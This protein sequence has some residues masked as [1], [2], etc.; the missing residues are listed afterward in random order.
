MKTKI[1]VIGS[2]GR[3]HALVWKVNQPN[4]QIYCAPGNG[5]ISTVA[6]CLPIKADNISGLLAFAQKENIDLTI[7]G[8]E[9]P[10]GLGIVDEFQKNHL[11]IFG[12]NKKAAQLETSKEFT[13]NFCRKY[14]LPTPNFATFSETI[15]AKK[16]VENKDFPLVIKASGLAA[17]KGV[18][19]VKNKQEAFLTVDKILEKKEFGKAGEIIVIEEFIVGQEVSMLAVC[20]GNTIIPLVPARDHKPLLDGNK[21][22]NTGGMGSYAPIPEVSKDWLIKIQTELFDPLLKALKKES[23]EYKGIIYAGLILSGDNFY[24]LEFNCRWGDPEAEVIIPLLKTD[25]VTLCYDTIEGKLKKL[26]WKDEYTVT[27]IA[28]SGGYPEKYETGKSITGNLDNQD[29]LI[30]FHC[31]TKKENNNYFTAGGR[32]L[33]VTGIGKTLAEAREKSYQALKN[34]GFDNIHYRTDIGK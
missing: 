32:V 27:V 3:E 26:D 1:L 12:P 2:G 25:M 24:I 7:V 13:K 4:C 21:G 17:G 8:P 11:K 29:N 10:L 22:P 28:A 15:K 31:G 9:V 5:G 23:I 18:I 33:A 30:I 16:Y 20:D 19:I 6:E 34:I 14:N